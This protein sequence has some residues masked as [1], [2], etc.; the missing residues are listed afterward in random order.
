[1]NIERVASP[2]VYSKANVELVAR[3]GVYDVPYVE[4]SWT[5]EWSDHM[6]D[7]REL[8]TKYD[9]GGVAALEADMANQSPVILRCGQAYGKQIV[10]PG[11]TYHVGM[12]LRQDVFDDP[13]EQAN[14]KAKYG[15]DLKPATT[16]KELRDQAEFFTRS[17]G[18]TLKGKPLDHDLYGVSMQA[19]AY[20]DNDEFSSYLWGKGAD[21]VSVVRD[22]AG[23]A[24]GIRD[25][26][27]RQ[28]C[29]DG[30]HE[31]VH[32]AAQVRLARLPDRE[33]RLRHCRYR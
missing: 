22:E 7:M 26:E 27:A 2:V 10:L 17:K 8:A 21:Y 15:Y 33:L 5:S 28:S 3:T 9:P 24:E 19:G 18:A 13:T 12:F 1:M 32:R 14:F 6:Y 4:T 25:H 20:Q 16:Y 23:N 31:P 11:Y 29:D 30:D